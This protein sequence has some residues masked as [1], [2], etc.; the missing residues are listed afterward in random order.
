[1][2]PSGPNSSTLE[3]VKP[4]VAPPPSPASPCSQSPPTGPASPSASSKPS[5]VNMADSPRSRPACT[6]TSCKTPM[7]Q[8][9][10][11]GSALVSN[12]YFSLQLWESTVST[13]FWI[14]DRRSRRSYERRHGRGFHGPR[15]TQAGEGRLRLH[16]F[17]P[18]GTTSFYD[19][20]GGDSFATTGG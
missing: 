15:S 1:M 19:C 7:V 17:P 11:R 14:A 5:P 4:L 20:G 2:D 10:A 6:A 9:M 16:R 18:L 3:V 8:V 12:R 13:S